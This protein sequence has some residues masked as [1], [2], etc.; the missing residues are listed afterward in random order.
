[1][2]YLEMLSHGHH[3][4]YISGGVSYR[5][6]SLPRQPPETLLFKV[7]YRKGRVA[8]RKGASVSETMVCDTPTWAVAQLLWL[9]IFGE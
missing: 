2:S 9:S 7:A 8:Y 6:H 4:M 3:C 5:K 1:M